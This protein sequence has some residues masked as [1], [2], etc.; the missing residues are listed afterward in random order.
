MRLITAASR[1]LTAC[2]LLLWGADSAH[3]EA[4]PTKP[5]RVVVPFAAGS[6]T[7]ALLRVLTE[8][9]G[10]RLGQPIIVDNRPGAGGMIGADI[11]AK[12]QP[13]GYTLLFTTNS[14]QV[15]NRYFFQKMPYDG[16]KDF[17][18][19]ALVGGVPHALVVNPSLP[20]KTV[21]ELIDYA[22]A[23]PDAVS[24]PYANSTGRIAG[25]IFRVMTLTKIQDVPYK[26]YGQAVSDLLGGQTQMMFIDFATGLPHIRA[27]RLRALAITP[28][29]SP[30]LPGVP[31]MKEVLPGFEVGNWNGLFAPVG[32]PQEIV[33]SLNRAM[34]EVVAMSGV[35]KAVDVMGYE[36]L[37]PVSP[38]EF[39]RY[40]SKEVAHYG[41]LTRSA[42][43]EP[44]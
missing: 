18:P 44:E 43:I 29:R 27:G 4:Y 23:R 8:P 32:T 34:T 10:K 20:I 25:S 3:A 41:Q 37:K 21:Q 36:L 15:A 14:T 12:A 31:A 35:R 22:K 9:L 7:D 28:G 13:D 26:A 17:A 24:F 42:G 5:L 33:E 1:L 11:V 39:K 38:E 30:L 16:E 2:A 40:V 6:P 19:V